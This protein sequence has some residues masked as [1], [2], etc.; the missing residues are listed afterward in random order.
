MIL[1][2]NHVRRLF[3]FSS[4]VNLVLCVSYGGR[5][6]TLGFFFPD[7][8]TRFFC[9]RQ[10]SPFNGLV[11]S[12]VLTSFSTGLSSFPRFS[13]QG[14]SWIF[15][16]V[17]TPYSLH[18]LLFL[19]PWRQNPGSVSFLFHG[20]TMRYSPNSLGRLLFFHVMGVLIWNR[21]PFRYNLGKGG[22]LP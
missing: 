13:G 8:L 20:G 22:D 16:I 3:S 17:G 5:S 10:C 1:L 7:P 15:R 11:Y 21:Y 18:P 9:L 4:S 6:W 12:L 14:A 2:F 19:F